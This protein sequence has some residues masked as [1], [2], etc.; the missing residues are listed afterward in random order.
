MRRFYLFLLIFPLGSS[1]F[2]QNEIEGIINQYAVVTSIGDCGE[3]VVVDNAAGF[4]EGDEILVYQAQGALIDQSNSAS[5]GSI[6]D[7]NTAGA[8][9]LNRIA[10]IDGNTLNL[11]IG[12]N[13]DFNVAGSVQVVSF[14]SFSGETFVVDTLTAKAWDGTSGGLLAFRVEGMLTLQAPVDV[15]GK[16]FRGGISGINGEN[17][18]SFINV[19]ND[20]ALGRNNWRGAMKGE[21]IAAY[22]PGKE[23]AR[24]PQASGGGGGNDHNSG[25]GGGGHLSSGG[26]GGNNEEPRALGCRGRRPGLGGNAIGETAGR[27]F[28]GGGGGAG[29]DN[30]N[31]ASDGGNGGGIVLIVADGFTGADFAIAANGVA[32]LVGTGDGAGGGGA[33]GTILMAVNDDIVGTAR[34]EAKGGNGGEQ[35]N[36]GQNRCMGPGGG[37]AGGVIFAGLPAAGQVVD[38]DGGKPGQSVNS[39]SCGVG[40]NGAE[41]GER[42]LVQ[43]WEGPVR[44]GGN[45]NEVAFSGPSSIAVCEASEG[46]IAM[47]VGSSSFAE[48]RW[49][50]DTGQG[51]VDIAEGP[52]FSGVTTPVLRILN[53]S[54]DLQ[55]ARFRLT[56]VAGECETVQVSDPVAIQWTSLPTPDFTT[57]SSGLTITFASESI[58]ADSLV[59]SFGDGGQDS[60]TGAVHSYESPGTYLVL[61][62]AFNEC[63]SRSLEQ[64][65]VVTNLPSRP[66]AS[67]SFDNGQGCTPVEVGFVNESSINTESLLWLFPGGDP[68]TSSDPNPT[69]RYNEAGVY[70]ATLI[71]FNELGADT[72]M[73]SE[74]VTVAPRPIADFD[75]VI[76]DLVVTFT[77][78][79]LE[80]EGYE[81]DFGDGA[82]SSQPAEQHTFSEYGN[83]DVRLI[84]SNDC[85]SDT[86]VRRVGLTAALEAGVSVASSMSCAPGFIRFFDRSAGNV[87]TRRWEF[88]GGEPAFS[89]EAEPLVRYDDV[90]SYDVRL[91]VENG[92]TA[93]SV[94]VEDAV[95]IFSA[96]NPSFT[97]LLD[98]AT[99]QFQNGS[100]NAT[101]FTW[102]FGDGEISVD[103]DPV[104]TY[105]AGGNYSVTLNA[106]NEFCAS[107]VSEMIFLGITAIEDPEVAGLIELYPN[108]FAGRLSIRNRLPGF[109]AL[110]L[111]VFDTLG[112]RVDVLPWR[113]E[114]GE[115]DLRQL[116]AGLYYLEIRAAA[117]G[118]FISM[119][120]V[121]KSKT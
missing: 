32:A 78:T 36:G 2:S 3:F 52:L 107:A 30:N 44:S 16:G 80:A 59:W 115:L 25:G 118:A 98:G 76:E 101:S 84:A 106:Q 88:P 82:G 37:G 5:F 18:C 35:D 97:Y 6:N 48:L 72:L 38:V 60:G 23:A 19:I 4:S 62:R 105:A 28:L 39:T 15:S 61:L 77:N 10:S 42:G 50:Q 119:K 27:I 21:G 87:T 12:L 13:H 17:N 79:S 54:E 92:S 83:Y 85:G 8:Y 51:F 24:G 114:A 93:D 113:G 46:L 103:A 71:A 67:F 40:T 34:L 55:D 91:I 90:G 20:Y 73:V 69:V 7:L 1:L 31:V 89:T 116:P 109:P 120:K 100:A 63:G 108:P 45:G 75:F 70:S 104:H 95:T 68:A 47:E 110:Q 11:S 56:T 58:N 57:A 96:P 41:A 102:N 86:L 65:I 81:W 74:I 112:R 53:P 29:H 26:I 121:I 66:T 9:E 49:Q 43:E 94:L 117:T 33:G 111:R 14:P 22:I 64:E 99:V